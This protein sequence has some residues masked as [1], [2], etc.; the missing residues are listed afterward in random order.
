MSIFVWWVV[1]W[2]SNRSTRKNNISL[3]WW[4]SG[5]GGRACLPASR[6]VHLF[7]YFEWGVSS[8]VYTFSKMMLPTIRQSYHHSWKL[9]GPVSDS[10]AE[11]SN[12]Y[13]VTPQPLTTQEGCCYTQSHTVIIRPYTIMQQFPSWR[14]GMLGCWDPLHHH[15]ISLCKNPKQTFFS[16]FTRFCCAPVRSFHPAMRGLLSKFVRP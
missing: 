16:F 12:S 6:V 14:K 8:L 3:C 4:M 15:S 7:V 2:Q 9:P 1:V 10:W 13:V 5:D 11:G